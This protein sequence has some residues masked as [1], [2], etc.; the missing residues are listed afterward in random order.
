MDIGL[1]KKIIIFEE[2]YPD[3]V[4]KIVITNIPDFLKFVTIL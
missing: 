1:F 4:Q 2:K 3:C